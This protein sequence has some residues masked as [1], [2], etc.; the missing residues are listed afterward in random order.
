MADSVTTTIKVAGMTCGHCVSAV[1]EE[2]GALE[3]VSD[4]AVDLKP[5][6]ESLVTLTSAWELDADA[7]RDAVDEAGYDV[8]EV[9]TA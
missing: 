9:A 1:T 3:G 5:G 2:L 4:V 6:E 7:I 8:V